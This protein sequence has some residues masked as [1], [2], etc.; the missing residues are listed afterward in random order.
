[1]ID[2]R[3]RLRNIKTKARI[4]GRRE[5]AAFMAGQRDVLECLADI[6]DEMIEREFERLQGERDDHRQGRV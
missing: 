3:Q 1:M 6:E 2:G 5:F 4:V